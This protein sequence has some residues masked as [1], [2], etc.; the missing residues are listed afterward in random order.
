MISPK[1]V[2]NV[3]EFL[4]ELFFPSFCLGCQKEGTLLCYDCQSTL[5]IS[6]YHYCLCNKNPLRLPPGQT[7]NG[8]C[9]SCQDRKL[10]GLYFALPY[11]EK[12]LTKKLIYQFKYEPYIKNLAK[13]L[14]GI[15]AEHLEI[16]G[17]NID[18]IWENSILV[19]V[20]MELKKQ[21][22]RGYNQAQELARE[23]GQM[24]N[25]PLAA[26]NLVKIKATLPQMELSAKDRQNNLKNAFFLKNPKEIQGKKVFLV[27]D[28]YT[29]GATMEECANVLRT[30]GAQQVWGIA[31]AREG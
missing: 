13:S 17:K 12:F 27:D 16:T 5:E 25:V 31:I 11:Q 4:L 22:N 20:P 10:S 2:D 29:T 18:P 24:L 7:N 26:G 8:K 19:P 6:E 21:K 1:H 9:Q 15:L 30:Q 3:K 23:L 28:V 14:A